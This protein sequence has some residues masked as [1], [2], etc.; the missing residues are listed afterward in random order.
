MIYEKP[1]GLINACFQRRKIQ[2]VFDVIEVFVF[3]F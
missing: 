3:L 1:N 2:L